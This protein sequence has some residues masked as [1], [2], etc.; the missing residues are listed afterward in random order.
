MVKVV[1]GDTAAEFNIMSLPAMVYFRKGTAL[2]YE[3]DLMDSASI[4]GWVGCIFNI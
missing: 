1:D 3:G 4:L 2:I